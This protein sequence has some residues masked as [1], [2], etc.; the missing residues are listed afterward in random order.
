MN[1]APWRRSHQRNGS[2]AEIK[3]LPPGGPWS[4][5]KVPCCGSLTSAIGL[6]PC[7]AGNGR[8]VQ[9]RERLFSNGAV[10]PKLGLI[11]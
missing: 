6:S 10:A 5:A 1:Q 11:P 8:D 9:S 3:H 4:R 7:R 2:P